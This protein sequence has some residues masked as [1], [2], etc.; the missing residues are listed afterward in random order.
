GAVAIGD[1]NVATGTGAVAIGADNVATGNGAV[2]IGN[3]S[4]AVGQGSV[5]LGNAAAAASNGVAV[6][7]GASNGAFTNSVALGAGSVNTAS[8]QVAVGGRTVSGVSAGALSETSTDAVNGS[9]LYVTNQAVAANTSAI[10]SFATNLSG[11]QNQVSTLF[12]L[13]NQDRKDMKQGV[14]SAIAMANAPM[15]SNPGGV[16]YAFNTAVFRGEA[17]VGGSINYRLNTENPTALSVGFSYAGNKNN[18][19]RAGIAGEF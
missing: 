14:A 13:R 16:G 12:D 17:A 3:Q 5:A 4:S 9:Q 7:N 2:A 8:N 6:G 1:P 15:P 19:F 10:A 18:G 11:M